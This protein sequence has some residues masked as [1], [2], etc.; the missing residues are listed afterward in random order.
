MGAIGLALSAKVCVP[1]AAQLMFFF[2]VVVACVCA[3]KC[4]LKV[5]ELQRGGRKKGG[6]GGGGA[7][8][9]WPSAMHQHQ[10]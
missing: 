8:L 1:E 9:L 3:I 4:L 7:L 6:V 5:E 10:I 2:N